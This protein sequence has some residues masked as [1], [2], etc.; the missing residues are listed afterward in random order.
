MYGKIKTIEDIT[1]KSGNYSE[2]E[3]Y[4]ITTDKGHE[5]LVLI[6]NGQSC[7]E[8]W[9][10]FSSEDDLENFIG[11]ELLKVN[12]V[13]SELRVGLVKQKTDYVEEDS[14]MFVNVETSIG[15]LQL[16][17]YNEHNGYYSH[18]VKVKWTEFEEDDYL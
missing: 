1:V 15:T 9:G 17:V 13:N 8:D 14:C 3:G 12:L 11:A 18:S 2:M 7:C 4:K 6:D 16:T 5:L 10:Y